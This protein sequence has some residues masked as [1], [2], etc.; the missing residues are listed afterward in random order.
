MIAEI[1]KR[2][3]II[4]FL[5]THEHNYLNNNKHQIHFDANQYHVARM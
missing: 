4:V 1:Y 5:F 2:E 3:R